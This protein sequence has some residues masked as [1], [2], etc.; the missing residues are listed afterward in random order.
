MAGGPTNVLKNRLPA[1]LRNLRGAYGNHEFCSFVWRSYGKVGD[2]MDDYAWWREALATGSFTVEEGN[3]QIGF[4]KTKRD[5]KWTPVAIWRDKES[6]ALIAAVG[7]RGNRVDPNSIWIGCAK[8]P[9]SNEAAITAFDT[10]LFPGDVPAMGHNSGTLS[11]AEEI[12]DVCASAMDWLRKLGGIK[13]AASKDM[14]ANWRDKIN[15]LKKQAD[16]E[17]ETE[18][19]PHLEASRAVDA[20]FKPVIEQADATATTLRDA[21]TV[22]MRAEEAKA[23]A[24]AEARH[25]AEMERVAKERARIAEEQAKLMKADPIAALTSPPPAE[26]E[27]P[28]FEAPAPIQAGGQRGRKTGLRT[29][30]KYVVTNYE[31]ALAHVKDHPDV[32]A[33]VEKVAAAQ[34]KAGATV[35][36]VEK[37]EEK[38]AA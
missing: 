16:A 28:I 35:P 17:R 27:L 37:Q 22:F 20:K 21:L 6:K 15:G 5:G 30:T 24:E 31:A 38:V 7:T 8:N 12:A 18:K 23:R 9:V 11:L 29:V 34:A 36:G 3:P 2:V 1:R 19:R 4:Y 33:A 26:P 14:A 25:K 13:D 10:G 32:R